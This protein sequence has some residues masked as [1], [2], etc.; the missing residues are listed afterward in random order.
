MPKQAY[1]KYGDNWAFERM[2]RVPT[3]YGVLNFKVVHE[4]G[5]LQHLS[6]KLQ[7]EVKRQV[8]EKI[9]SVAHLSRGSG[10]SRNTLSK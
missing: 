3:E 8:E 1:K 10:L 7:A 5:P 2:V 9:V 6:R 4:W